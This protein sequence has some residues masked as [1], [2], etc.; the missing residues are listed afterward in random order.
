MPDRAKP[1]KIV[2]VF[3]LRRDLGDRHE[4][5]RGS[6]LSRDAPLHRSLIHSISVQP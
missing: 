6:E 5:V 1:I 4:R 2:N 3:G